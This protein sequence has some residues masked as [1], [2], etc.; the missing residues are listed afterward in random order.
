MEVIIVSIAYSL[1]KQQKLKKLLVSL[2]KTVTI[3]IENDDLIYLKANKYSMCFAK[4][5]ENQ[6]TVTWRISKDFLSTN[7]FSWTP[8]YTLSG[9]IKYESGTEII[10]NTNTVEIALGETSI[11]SEYGLFSE[12]ITEG[13]EISINIDNRY[14]SDIHACISQIST[15]PDGITKIAPIYVTP[16]LLPLGNISLT[17]TEII[18][19][20]FEQNISTKIS[21]HEARTNCYEFDMT[22][23]NEDYI[24][25]K[26]RNWVKE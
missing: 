26:N 1:E 3:N 8:Q 24:T 22:S 12:P 6:Y 7:I 15:A 9:T 25:Y 17:T 2:K 14:S 5:V 19:V 10:A 18:N 11:L 4:K 21:I 16:F 23:K 13:K 20:W